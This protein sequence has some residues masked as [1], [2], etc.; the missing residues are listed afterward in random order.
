MFEFEGE[1]Y[2]KAKNLQ[3]ER[4]DCSG[5][6]KFFEINQED[7]EIQ[8]DITCEKP[9]PWVDGV[10]KALKGPVADKILST[11]LSLSAAMKAKDS[12]DSKVAR[13]K[14]ERAAAAEAF[15][16]TT[17]ATAE[18]RTEITAA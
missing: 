9:G 10:K 8:V 13:D 7:D 18:V 14:A 11:I 3:D 2:F 6:L 5:K 4:T 1:L 16:Q 17:Q 12:D 15:K